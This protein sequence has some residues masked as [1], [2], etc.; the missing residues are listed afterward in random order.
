MGSGST[1]EGIGYQEDPGV[2]VYGIASQAN[3]IP[4]AVESFVVLTNYETR[5]RE[6]LYSVDDS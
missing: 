6:K 1:I 3:R 4:G 2:E 5:S